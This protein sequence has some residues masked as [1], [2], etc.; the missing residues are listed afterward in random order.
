MRSVN[1]LIDPGIPRVVLNSEL[2]IKANGKVG[3]PPVLQPVLGSR[4]GSL[5]ERQPGL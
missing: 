5:A 1:R 4:S 3:E 2:C